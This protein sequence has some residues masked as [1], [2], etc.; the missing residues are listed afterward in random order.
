MRLTAPV[1]PA[2]G[3]AAVYIVKLKEPGAASYKGGAAGFA[4]TKPGAGQSMNAHAAAVQTYVGRLEQTHDRLLA[5]VGAAGAKV[6]SYSYA[7]NGFAAELTAAQVVAARAAPRGRA[8]LAR[9]RPDR[10]HEQ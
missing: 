7:L 5:E 8:D 4:A 1:R 9:H 6:Y 2:K 3:G 10:R